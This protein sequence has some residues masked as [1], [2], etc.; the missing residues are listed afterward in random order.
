MNGY[1][2]G[3]RTAEWCSSGW[4]FRVGL[5]VSKKLLFCKLVSERRSQLKS[6][7]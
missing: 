3:V 2:P 6:K 5:Y 1:Q 7:E 4:T